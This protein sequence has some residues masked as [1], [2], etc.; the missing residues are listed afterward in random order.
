VDASQLKPGRGYQAG[1]RNPVETVSSSLVTRPLREKLFENLVRSQR[2][3]LPI[4]TMISSKSQQFNPE[5]PV[6]EREFSGFMF[7]HSTNQN[8]PTTPTIL[9]FH[10]LEAFGL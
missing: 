5:N 9:V 10:L 7:S 6:V 8:K 3:K 1:R 2:E 4:I